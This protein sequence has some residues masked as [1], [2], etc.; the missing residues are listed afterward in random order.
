MVN[1]TD[2]VDRLTVSNS[3]DA[4]THQVTRQGG[5]HYAGKMASLRRIIILQITILATPI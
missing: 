5:V 4:K 3:E 2:M 1:E